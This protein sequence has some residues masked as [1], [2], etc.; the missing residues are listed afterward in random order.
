VHLIAQEI[1][2]KREQLTALETF[3][4]RQQ[5]SPMRAETFRYIDF[6]RA[7]LKEAEQALTTSDIAATA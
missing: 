4:Q 5:R 2:H 6:W 3:A 1:R 7:R